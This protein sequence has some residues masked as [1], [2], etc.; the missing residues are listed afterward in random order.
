[1]L[2]LIK[3]LIK[4]FIDIDWVIYILLFLF[5]FILGSTLGQ[6]E[7]NVYVSGQQCQEVIQDIYESY[8]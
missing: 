6:P 7:V 8:N 5:G 2:S 1:M 3:S 4:K